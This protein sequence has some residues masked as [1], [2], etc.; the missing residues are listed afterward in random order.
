MKEIK[1]PKEFMLDLNW[2]IEDL[3]KGKEMLK[4]WDARHKSFYKNKPK[5]VYEVDMVQKE[6]LRN[7]VNFWQERLSN[8]NK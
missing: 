6:H 3:I 4:D 1:T 2:D 8:E 5:Y 7:S